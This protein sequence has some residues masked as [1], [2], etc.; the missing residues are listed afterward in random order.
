VLATIY[1]HLGVD[2]EAQYLD[3]GRPVP[4]LPSGKVIEE[5]C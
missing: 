3:N 4:V 1:S 5:L 2:T